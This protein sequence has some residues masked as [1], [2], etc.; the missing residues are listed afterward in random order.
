MWGGKSWIDF[1]IEIVL[2]TY[3]KSSIRRRPCIVLDPKF[4]RLVLEVV[5][6]VQS[7]EQKRFWSERRPLETLKTSRKISF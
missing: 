6:K 7:M 4:H 2:H 1:T 5:Q 3:R